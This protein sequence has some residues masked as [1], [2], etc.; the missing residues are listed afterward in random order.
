V[1]YESILG[2]S[3]IQ[4]EIL[5][6]TNSYFAFTRNSVFVTSRTDVYYVCV[7]RSVH[8]RGY[9]VVTDEKDL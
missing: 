3:N 1:C 5:G 9:I 2:M 6:R 4:K 8:L 7:N